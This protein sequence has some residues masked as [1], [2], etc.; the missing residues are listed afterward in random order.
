MIVLFHVSKFELFVALYWLKV[1]KE[2]NIDCQCFKTSSTP[3]I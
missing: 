3:E 1:L 2:Y